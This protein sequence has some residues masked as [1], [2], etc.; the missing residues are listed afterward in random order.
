MS[1]NV[2]GDSYNPPSAYAVDFEK[3]RFSDIPTDELFWLSDSPNSNTNTAHRKISE[4]EGMNTKTRQIS[5]FSISTI[6]YQKI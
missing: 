4:T 2:P 5:T 1:N 6:T 3:F